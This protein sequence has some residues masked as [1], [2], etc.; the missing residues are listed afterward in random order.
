[1]FTQQDFVRFA[2]KDDY[3]DIPMKRTVPITF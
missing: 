1:M 2:N 3:A